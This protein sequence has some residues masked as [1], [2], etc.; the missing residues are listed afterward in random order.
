M[1][2]IERSIVIE[3]SNTSIQSRSFASYEYELLIK[4]ACFSNW[5]N[6]HVVCVFGFF[7][8]N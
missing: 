1:Q 7:F 3:V 4:M 5:E 2:K 6:F 8:L